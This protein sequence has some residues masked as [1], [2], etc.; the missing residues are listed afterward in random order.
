[1]YRSHVCVISENGNGRQPAR[2]LPIGTLFDSLFYFLNSIGFDLSYTLW[3]CPMQ[4]T[5]GEDGRTTGAQKRSRLVGR[6][7]RPEDNRRDQCRYPGAARGH[8]PPLAAAALKRDCDSGTR[9]FVGEM[10]FR[11]V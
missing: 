6:E 8:P 2:F 11:V 3:G 1:M 5:T 9:S 10:N 7:Q 4:T